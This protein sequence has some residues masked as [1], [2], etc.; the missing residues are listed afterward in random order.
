MLRL[1]RRFVVAIVACGLC[2]AGYLPGSP[3]VGATV[4]APLPAGPF[5]PI[6]AVDFSHGNPHT[7][8][9]GTY[10]TSAMHVAHG[11]LTI[12]VANGFSQFDL[13][14]VGGRL[15]D[16]QIATLVR[17]EGNGRVGVMARWS[18]GAAGQWTLYAFWITN[19]GSAGVTRWRG[20]HL[21]DLSIRR[22]AAVRPNRD[23]LLVLRVRGGAITT[24]LNGAVVQ[25]LTDQRALHTGYWGLFVSSVTGNGATQGQFSRAL[26]A[27]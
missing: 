7:W 12:S 13:P 25:T 23:N 5:T 6:V 10:P 1:L 16:G 24:Y 26:I 17:P 4:P 11:R 9:E 8:F 2:A 15:A 19:H 3:H 27:G 22:G 18:G 14:K 21:S 20:A